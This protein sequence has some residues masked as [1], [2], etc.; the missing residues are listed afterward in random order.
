MTGSSGAISFKGLRTDLGE[1]FV[2]NDNFYDVQN[3]NY[4]DIIGANSTLMPE[5]QYDGDTTDNID[6][7]FQF[8]YLNLAGE[9]TSEDI[10]SYGGKVYSHFLGTPTLI[11]SGLT[12]GKM[13]FAV[14]HNKL[15]MVNG[16][17]YPIVYDGSVVYEMGA[18]SAMESSD[19]GNPTGTYYY[20]MTYVTGSGE[21]RI[22]T[23]SNTITVTNKK[24]QLTIPI[25]Y[26]GTTS[27]KIYR[28]T[29]GGSTPKL[30]TTIADNTTTSYLDNVSDGS[31][32]A[33]IG[34]INNEC[35]KP[36][37]IETSYDKL[38][39]AVIDID[40]TLVAISDSG[41]EVWD[42]AQMQDVSS[43]GNDSTRLMGMKQ[44]YSKIIIGS[45]KE[46]YVMDVSDD[47][48]QITRTRS[49]VGVLNGYAMAT[50]PK[51][52]DFPGGVM[53]LTTNQDVRLFNGNFSDAPVATSLDNLK[54]DNFSQPIINVLQSSLE[55]GLNNYAI[56]F[57]YKYILG[58]GQKIFTFDIRTQAWSILSVMT[59]S[60]APTYN[61]FFVIGNY[62]YGGQL[63]VS[64]VDQFY[65]G[66]K[67]RGEDV[68]SYVQSGKILLSEELKYFRQ[69]FIYFVV[70]ENLPI[71]LT[72][73][74]DND[75]G[76]Q[77]SATF[78][79][80]LG[81]YDSRYFDDNYYQDVNNLEDYRVLYVN[82][83]CRWMDYRISSTNPFYFRG[84]RAEYKEIS[85]KE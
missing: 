76:N 29:N 72:L 20:E 34:A 33:D 75:T 79:C 54:A 80:G 58:I 17:N 41:I 81:A 68:V 37:F 63:S 82:R 39:G 69:F 35:P 52:A 59:D 45:E 42:A 71:T 30:V 66:T 46:I 24:I 84:F 43:V 50:V 31:L 70:T 53:F 14:V 6:G 61:V 36:Y 57:D 8:R 1:A 60:Y 27:R 32:G 22:G 48:A 5:V 25:G 73:T 4:D 11:K 40:P 3:I 47:T 9:Y 85:N 18:P 26:S 38:V 65:A 2:P 19:I 23:R 7:G 44:D 56:Y 28:T 83:Y 74:L 12:P 16:L 77:I 51:Y 10:V 21:E 55:L 64:M 78:D 13:Q 15:F 62:L 49:N 67:Y